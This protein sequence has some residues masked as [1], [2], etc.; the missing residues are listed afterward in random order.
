MPVLHLGVLVQS[1]GNGP[2]A[3]DTADVAGWLEDKYHVM[4]IFYEHHDKQ[5]ADA[6]ANS[7][8]GALETVMMGGPAG[9]PFASA[10]D[11]IH[12]EFQD[13]I[14][15]KEMDRLGYPGVPTQASLQGVSHRHKSRRGSPGRPSFYDTGLYVNSFRA[16]TDQ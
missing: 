13:F 2:S 11:E 1:Y 15:T 14:L 12:K 8:Q 4:E 10:A 6:M 9:D 7:M 3:V 16:W 5:I